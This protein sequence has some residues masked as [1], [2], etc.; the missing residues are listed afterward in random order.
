MERMSLFQSTDCA[1]ISSI[2]LVLKIANFQ[3]SECVVINLNA[4]FLIL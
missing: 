3:L 1:V 4:L 2:Y